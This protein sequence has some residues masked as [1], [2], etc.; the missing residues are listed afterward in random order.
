MAAGRREHDWQVASYVAA[1]AFNG[2]LLAA[3]RTC[4]QLV[5][6]NGKKPKPDRPKLL[7]PSDINP[8]TAKRRPRGGHFEVPFSTFV[9]HWTGQDPGDSRQ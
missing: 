1:Y 6:V 9:K 8:L 3:D 5:A 2:A 7:D 4:K